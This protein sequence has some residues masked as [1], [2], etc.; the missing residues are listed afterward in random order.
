MDDEN[1]FETKPPVVRIG[2]RGLPDQINSMMGGGLYVLIAKT[3]SARFPMLAGSIANA[4]EEGLVCTL[5]APTNP[6]SFIQRIETLA[7]IDTADLV[8][9]NLLQIFVAQ[10]NFLKKIFQFGAQ[11]FVSE[12][13]DFQIPENSYLVF[14]QA[15]ELLSLHDVSLALEQVNILKNW[16]SRKN[17]TALLVFSR[18]SEA[19][20]N[21]VN[22][23]M[24]HLNGIVR[25]GGERDGLELTFDYWQSSEG[26]VVAKNYQLLTL[27]TGLYEASSRSAILP[28]FE[29][30]EK[31]KALGRELAMYAQAANLN[32]LPVFVNPARYRGYLPVPGFASEVNQIIDPAKKIPV[33]CM[34]IVGKVFKPSTIPELVDNCSRLARPG[35]LITADHKN[36]YIF[37]NTKS[38]QAAL[39]TL[40]D[41]LGISVANVFEHIKFLIFPEEITLELA[42]L[43]RA[44]E[45]GN[46]TDFS[47]KSV[48]TSSWQHSSRDLNEKTPRADYSP[49][50]TSINIS[51]QEDKKSFFSV[52]SQVAQKSFPTTPGEILLLDFEPAKRSVVTLSGFSKIDRPADSNGGIAKNPYDSTEE[53]LFNC[54]SEMH[55]PIFGKKEALRATRNLS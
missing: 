2:I 9:T 49:E 20:N 30:E 22:A 25:L 18:L 38:Q 40:D 26:V 35:E 24:D 54:D 55:G 1:S 21:T 51:A 29:G 33:S 28:S 31:Y 34:L 43:S 39:K 52:A 27:D 6:Q 32:A 10:D 42:V 23:I 17:I 44:A 19:H 48:N 11:R 47:S 16:F 12:L 46:F 50:L 41:I 14:D 4:L 45:H 53:M 8:A 15:D 5:I 7:Q 36:C 13:E 3:T 37:L